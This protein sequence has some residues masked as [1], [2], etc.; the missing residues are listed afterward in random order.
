MSDSSY[1]GRL[2]PSP[3]GFMH[4]GMAR[5]L[6][7]AWADARAHGGRIHLRIEDIDQG[8]CRPAFETAILE[9]LRWL[10][11]DWDGP[12]TRQSEQP[13]R[14]HHAL[15]ALAR[16]GRLY[17]CRCSRKDIRA[18]AGAPHEGEAQPR[19]PGRC[20]PKAPT[21]LALETVP[22]DAALRLRTE[23]TDL[24]S[25]TD[26]LYGERTEDVAT[27]VGDFVVRRRDGHPAYQ[28]AVA[29]DD[30]HDGI[31]QVVRGRDL[32]PSSPRQTLLRKLLDPDA[33][34]IEWRHLP[35]VL[36]PG[37][38]RLATR[39]GARSLRA[40]RAD[41]HSPSTILLAVAKSLGQPPSATAEALAHHWRIGRCPTTDGPMDLPDLS[42]PP[43]PGG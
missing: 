42:A 26:R 35:L 28:L 39:D 7:A 2:A 40:L 1:V 15:T 38:K 29:V 34:A 5:T 4:L 11:L 43:V 9:D 17:P 14:Y 33:P 3:T 10:G 27:A 30:L 16:K 22:K 20:R 23:T 21:P 24:I 41:G 36:D 32:W 25:V 37:R 8:R 19:Y 13:D 18:A 6:V 12:L 31:R